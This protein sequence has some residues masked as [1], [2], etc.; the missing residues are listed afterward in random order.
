MRPLSLSL[1]LRGRLAGI[2]KWVLVEGQEGE[3]EED[4]LSQTSMCR[5]EGLVKEK[6]DTMKSDPG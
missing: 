6:K 4:P 1:P 2:V 3:Y 5:R